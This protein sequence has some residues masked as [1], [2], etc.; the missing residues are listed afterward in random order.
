MS[1]AV[2]NENQ[3]QGNENQTRD[4]KIQI[5]AQRNPSPPQQNQNAR[6]LY[7]YRFLNGLPIDSRGWGPRRFGRAAAV[8]LPVHSPTP[9]LKNLIMGSAI[10]QENVDSFGREFSLESSSP[11]PRIGARSSAPKLVRGRAHHQQAQKEAP[12]PAVHPLTASPAMVALN[13]LG[14]NPIGFTGG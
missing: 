9:F 8:P 6:S 14:Q 2:G 1:S 13:A 5:P 3:A 4:N 11:G 10:W 7:E 12:S